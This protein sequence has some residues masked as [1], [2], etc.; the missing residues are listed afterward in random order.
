MESVRACSGCLCGMFSLHAL[1]EQRQTSRSFEG[2]CT[3]SE[4]LKGHKW[5]SLSYSAKP[6]RACAPYKQ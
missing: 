1:L 2:A 4:G 5:R 3:S 6:A